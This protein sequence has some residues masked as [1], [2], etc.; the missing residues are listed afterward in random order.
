M[1]EQMNSYRN[2]LV[3][4][5]I[6]LNLRDTF[7]RLLLGI[8]RYGVSLLLVLL[9]IT[10]ASVLL[11]ANS[12]K[13]MYEKQVIYT[14]TITGGTS[15][16]NLATNFLSGSF[17]ELM[18]SHLNEIIQGELNLSAEDTFDA[19][20]EI[21]NS[22]NMLKLSVESTNP[23]T[24]DSVMNVLSKYYPEYA[25]KDLGSVSLKEI[26]DSKYLSVKDDKERLIR[27]LLIG[28]AIGLVFDA[29]FLVHYT[30]RYKTIQS[31]ATISKLTSLRNYGV[32]PEITV[33]K[34]KRKR[35]AQLVSKDLFDQEIK[36]AALK[37]Q[38]KAGETVMFV[39]AKPDEGVT[40]ITTSFANY[41]SETN[42][43]PLVITLVDTKSAKNIMKKI[44][45]NPETYSS[46]IEHEEKY[47]QLSIR[48][49]EFERFCRENNSSK[50]NSLMNRLKAEYTSI[51]I[52]SQSLEKSDYSPSFAHVADRVIYIV[53]QGSTEIRTVQD[54]L[55]LLENN[56]FK[57]SGY[58]LNYA[59]VESGYYG[60]YS[61]S[62]YSK[63]YSGIQTEDAEGFSEN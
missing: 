62:A 10:V 25:A 9:S 33:G 18:E 11:W 21:L 5:S 53:K 16:D 44:A 46:Y 20:V 45:K 4:D 30:F 36:A 58:L 32:L 49:N 57:L 28:L 37:L 8:R 47:D 13:P 51:L 27:F 26:K 1:R 35:R 39:A 17:T 52:D 43:H 54:N 2:D 41:L 63:Y 60:S 6:V 7:N 42:Q 38:L 48:F 3:D 24:A 40:T 59:D 23:E 12:Y 15:Q 22:V 34:A 19:N 61:K 14:V 56:G 50:L 29:L 55:E 31:T